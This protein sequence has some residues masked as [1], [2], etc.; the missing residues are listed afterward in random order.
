MHKPTVRHWSIIKAV[1]RL[2]TTQYTGF[3]ILVGERAANFN[4]P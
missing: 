2:R 3:D 1:V 4:L